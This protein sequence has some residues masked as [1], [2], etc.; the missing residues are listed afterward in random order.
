MR[1]FQNRLP[2]G[3]RTS[4]ESPKE[5]LRLVSR[6]HYDRSVAPLFVVFF[7]SLKSIVVCMSIC[8]SG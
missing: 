8:I 5:R 1:D 2:Q 3:H 6:A 4:S 7:I